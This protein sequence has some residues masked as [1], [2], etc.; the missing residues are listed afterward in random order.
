MKIKVSQKT[1]NFS[2]FLVISIFLWLLVKLSQEYTTIITYPIEYKNFPENKINIYE[3]PPKLRLKITAS[4]FEIL[5]YQITSKIMPITLDVASAKLNV[6]KND[7][8]KIFI[9]TFTLL[10]TINAQLTDRKIIKNLKVTEIKPDTLFFHF[11]AVIS[12]RV[13]LVANTEIAFERQYMQ[14]SEIVLTPDSILIKGPKHIVDT[15]QFLETELLKLENI[16]EDTKTEINIK[17]YKNIL[18]LQKT[19]L[20]KIQVEQFTE[21]NVI[22]PINI[23]NVP[24][25]LILKIFPNKLKINYLVGVSNYNSINSQDFVVYVD[26]NDIKDNINNKLKIKFEKIPDKI[27]KYTYNPTSTEYLIEK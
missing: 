8:N 20:I 21:N 11:T 1:V 17:E 14:K 9:E 24:D 13:K 27:K 4:G 23:K 22:I 12:K 2:F 5:K 19:T 10:Q 26:F 25:S 6:T 16:K 7:T 3:L 15:I 18:F